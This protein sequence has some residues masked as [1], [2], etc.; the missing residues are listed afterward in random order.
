LTHSG[1][2]VLCSLLL[3][4]EN[5]TFI[6]QE[7]GGGHA[8]FSAGNMVLYDLPN[9]NCQLEIPLIRYENDLRGR[10]FP[11]GSGIRPDHKIVQ[12]PKD[13]IGNVDTVMEFAL[14]MARSSLK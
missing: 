2:A 12:S 3:N 6:G 14:G 10:E 8:A 9:T 1:G 4:N 13:L 11:K 5:V 7:T